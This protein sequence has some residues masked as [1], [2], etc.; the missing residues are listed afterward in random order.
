[1]LK[2]KMEK[3]VADGRKIQ[4]LSEIRQISNAILLT[5]PRWNLRMKERE[6]RL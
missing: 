6:R 1:M 4:A 2:L 5:L 3:C